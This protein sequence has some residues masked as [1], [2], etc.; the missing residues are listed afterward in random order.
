MAMLDI[1]VQSVQ[2]VLPAYLANASPTVLIKLKKHPIDFGFKL[3]KNRLLGDG[4]TIEGFILA[5]IVGYLSG[6][7]VNYLLLILFPQITLFNLPSIAFL[8]IG[9]GA[10]IGDMT[11]SFFKRRMGM[12]RGANA[13]LL[14]MEDF[15]IGSLIAARFFVSYSWWTVIIALLATPILHRLAN[16]I[17]YKIGVKKE[18]W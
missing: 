10:M 8:F 3:G 7:L 18:P 12:P 11:G 16:I 14:D 4:K 6:Y 1:L 5:C 17:G 13:G 15:I 2:I 9:M